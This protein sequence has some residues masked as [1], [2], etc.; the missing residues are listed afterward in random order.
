MLDVSINTVG[1]GENSTLIFR[2]LYLVPIQPRIKIK[3]VPRF[4]IAEY[5]AVK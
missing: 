4:R 2:S 3:L 5:F 1:V